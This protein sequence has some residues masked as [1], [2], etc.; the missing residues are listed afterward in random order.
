M[1]M[2]YAVSLMDTSVYAETG[3]FTT[4]AV[5]TGANVIVAEKGSKSG[6]LEHCSPVVILR[7]KAS[8][9]SA[10]PEGGTRFP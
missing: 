5:Q 1:K 8:R 4:R 7:F 2:M 3:G 6:A 10:E 9:D